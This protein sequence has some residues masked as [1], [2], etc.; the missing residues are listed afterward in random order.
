MAIIRTTCPTC[1]QVDLGAEAI[2]LQ[3]AHG[4][5]QGEYAFTCPECSVEVSKLADSKIIGLLIAAGASAQETPAEPAERQLPP[6]P[7]ED[8]SPSPDASAF[9]LDDVIDFHFLL[10]DDLWNAELLESPR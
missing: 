7:P 3:V 2:S 6:L 9:T 8:R 10:Q 5:E 1:G 4:G